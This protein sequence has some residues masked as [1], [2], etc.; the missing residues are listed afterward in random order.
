MGEVPRIPKIPLTHFYQTRRKCVLINWCWYDN[1]FILTHREK[2][3]KQPSAIQGAAKLLSNVSWAF[4]CRE[5]QLGHTPLC[6]A[7]GASKTCKPKFSLTWCTNKERVSIFKSLDTIFQSHEWSLTKW[8][9]RESNIIGLSLFA[10]PRSRFCVV[11][12]AKKFII[13]RKRFYTWSET[14]NEW[15]KH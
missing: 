8:N 1:L 15:P 7:G 9:T 10:L 14:W 12:T 13:C 5:W 4:Q 2:W 6:Y 3:R 11:A